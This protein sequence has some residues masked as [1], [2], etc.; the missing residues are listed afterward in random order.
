MGLTVFYSKVTLEPPSKIL[1]S[2]FYGGETEAG[3]LTGGIQMRVVCWRVPWP[4]PVSTGS[5]NAMQ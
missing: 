5:L 2:P 1:L 3:S 4:L